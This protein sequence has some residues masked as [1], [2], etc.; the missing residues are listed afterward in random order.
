MFK[1]DTN[2]QVTKKAALPK[3]TYGMINSTETR[4]YKFVNPELP[5]LSG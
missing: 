4:G 2:P 1:T 3:Q 5:H